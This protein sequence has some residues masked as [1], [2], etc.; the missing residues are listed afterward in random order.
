MITCGGVWLTQWALLMMFGLDLSVILGLR[1]AM[2][3]RGFLWQPLTYM[4]LHSPLAISHILFNML[5]LW[6]MGGELERVWGSR[7]FL[8]YYLVTGFGAGMFSLVMGLAAGTAN[9]I[10]IGASG[11]I[12]G[13][14]IAYGVL[15]GERTILFMMMIPMKARTFAWIMF[16]VAFFSTWNP[17]SGGVA[18][19]AHLGG[20]VTGF[21]YLKRA[22]RVGP[23][24]SELRWKVRRRRF[25]VLDRDD[26]QT[27]H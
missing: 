10:T 1:P 2:V 27:F 15:F 7:G 19:I 22:W 20:A 26:D 4:F 24:L 9:T 21:L 16:A 25:R 23:F 8:R 3:I 12:F 5:L 13:L 17:S 11:A 14:I 6:M 18:H